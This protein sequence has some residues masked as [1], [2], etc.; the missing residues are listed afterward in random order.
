[1]P[2]ELVRRMAGSAR[3]PVRPKAARVGPTARIVSAIRAKHPDVPI[4]GFPKGAGEKLPA[5]V[6]ETKV[7]AVALDE[8]G[9]AAGAKEQEKAEVHGVKSQTSKAGEGR[10]L[11]RKKRQVRR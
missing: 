6:R 10:N 4:I 3:V 5:Y 7:D 8:G 11:R 2:R 1:M 9:A